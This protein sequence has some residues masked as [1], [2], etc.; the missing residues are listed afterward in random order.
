MPRIHSDRAQR[1]GQERRRSPQHDRELG[2]ILTQQ[3]MYNAMLEAESR[4]APAIAK[5]L[6]PYFKAMV[7]LA[8][9]VSAVPPT[10]G[11]PND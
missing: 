7:L 1:S 6:L 8:K 2:Q 9:A 11:H 3:R 10:E 5:Q 4:I